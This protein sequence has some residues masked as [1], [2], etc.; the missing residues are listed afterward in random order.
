[1]NTLV[2]EKL[3]AVIALLMEGNA[4]RGVER[5]TRV[6]RNTVMT[7]K[8]KLVQRGLLDADAFVRNRK[9]NCN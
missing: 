5:L 9:R 8:N 7:I 2:N 3:E 1:M 6:H 4:I